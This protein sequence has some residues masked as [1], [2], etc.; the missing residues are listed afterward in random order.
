MSKDYQWRLSLQPN[1]LIDCQDRGRWYPATIMSR[2]EEIINGMKK[3]DYRIGFRIYPAT[4]PDWI[5]Y[6]KF[7]PEKTKTTDSNNRIYFGDQE[8]YDETISSTSKRIQCFGSYTG[9]VSNS[10]NKP[11]SESE[12]ICIDDFIIFELKGQRFYVIGKSSSFSYYYAT[13]IANFAAL[14]GF[15]S[16]LNLLHKNAKEKINSEL[17]Y[18]IFHFISNS[19]SL[20]HKEYIKQLSELMK[21]NVISYLNDLNQNDLRN[22]KK[23][24]IELITKVLRYYLS[25]SLSVEERNEVVENFGLSFSLKMLRTS[26]LDKRISAVKT[27]VDIIK[28]SKS[29]PEKC[30]KI[31]KMIEDYKIFY[32]I[33]GPNS[34]IQLI[35]KSKDLLEIML[36]EDKLSS[37]EMEI[38]WNATKKGDLEG[39]LTILKTLKE[40]SSSLKEKHIKMLLTSIYQSEPHVLINEEIDLIYD[41]AT[42]S[43]QP[44]SELE[45]CIKFFLNGLFASKT[46]DAEKTGILV[47]KIF[48][49]TKLNK[50]LKIAILNEL[51]SNIENNNNVYLSLKL[52]GKFISD[53]N[54]KEKD[55]NNNNKYYN[56]NNSG[57][58]S[59]NKPSLSI[60]EENIV[61]KS[62]IV[63][64]FIKNFTD[65]KAC[66]KAML[67]NKNWNKD[68][69][70]LPFDNF[71]YS[72]NL[73]A[74]LHFLNILILENVWTSDIDPI[75]F[76]FEILNNNSL[77]EKD[78][79]EFYKWIKKF[80][81]RNLSIEMEEKIFNLFNNKICADSKKCQNLSIQAFESY[82]RVFLDINKIK[83]NLEYAYV[84]V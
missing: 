20:F 22:M 8:G 61:E 45:K 72:Q 66:I 41:L 56:N 34:H 9:G 15:E 5:N 73:R 23:E 80:I 6:T 65:F 44:E 52:L 27:I 77:S 71:T 38:I 26:L 69:D 58:I 14:G 19:S 31:L 16:L 42:H 49:I 83:E 48:Q 37:G 32:E 13:L 29:E 2:N 39:K 68:I 51:I 7:W 18:Y 21:E 30:A 74:R 35:N 50:N 4:F 47:N 62:K 3:V 40:I 76:V 84:G 10:Q 75:D 17:L 55:N 12:S 33:Y 43:T 36:Q 25:Y 64:L 11:L 81:E 78:S 70:L 46:D 24:T 57:G 63:D 67:E 54:E 1:D 79:Q 28:S 53:K 82:L 60:F 59:L